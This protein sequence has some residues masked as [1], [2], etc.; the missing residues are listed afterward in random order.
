MDPL[1]LVASA[2]ALC[3]AGERIASLMATMKPYFTA[4][5]DI[6]ALNAE[7]ATVKDALQHL[8]PTTSWR[9][10]HEMESISRM[11]AICFTHVLELENLVAKAT[12]KVR[13]SSGFAIVKVS[14]IVWLSKAKKAARV[15]R[16]LEESLL[17]IMRCVIFLIW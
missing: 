8:T 1:S 7:I 11:V 6:A 13:N 14:R 3:Q 5:S 9:D 15:Q 17:N 2:I 10:S 4:P 16:R 12:S